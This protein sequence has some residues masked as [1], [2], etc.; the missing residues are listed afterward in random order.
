MEIQQ[1]IRINIDSICVLK[2]VP[3][4]EFVMI[5]YEPINRPLDVE[6]AELRKQVSDENI[7]AKDILTY[8]EHHNK[9][10]VLL[11][12]YNYCELFAGAYQGLFNDIKIM[13]NI[14]Q[15]NFKHIANKAEYKRKEKEWLFVDLEKKLQA[16]YLEETYKICEEKRLQ[17]SILAY[18]HRVAGWATPKYDLNSNFSI[19]IKTNFGFGYVSY[20]YTI[21]TYK[22][23][24]IIAFSDWIE[25]EKAEL[26][27]I[28]RY[29]ARHSLNND[30]W[31]NALEYSMNA[32]NL[33]IKDENA[34]VRK[35]IIDECEKMVVGIEEILQKDKFR[36]N[37][38]ERIYIEVQR[39]GH[40]LIE[41]RGEKLSG[42]LSFIENIIQ[43]DKIIETKEFITRIENC[44]KMVVSLLIKE[45][46]LIKLELIELNKLLEEL[47]PI[48]EELNKQH[49]IYR[50]FWR[51]LDEEMYK[52]YGSTDKKNEI[53]A[54]TFNEQYPNYVEFENLFSPKKKEYDGLIAQ[55]LSLETTKNNIETYHNTINSYFENKEQ[56]MSERTTK[57]HIT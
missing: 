31:K 25:Y 28:V 37:N 51:E 30:N 17:K 57:L 22:Q 32:C 36:F 3:N 5:D 12:T 56:K 48:Y 40:N 8:I 18:S 15:S 27:E 39:E 34:F 46:P 49:L 23:I 9:L 38:K 6:F 42:A 55:I 45:L 26:L 24:R 16:Y 47:T 2:F 35:H 54:K 1:E 52:L 50:A 19:E 44:N 4:S 20:F 41:L 7:I 10:C 53:L 29:S 33:S 43:F 11:N 14:Y 13:R 21:I